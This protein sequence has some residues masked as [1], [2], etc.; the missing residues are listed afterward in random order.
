MASLNSIKSFAILKNRRWF[1]QFTYGCCVVVL[2]VCLF[3]STSYAAMPPSGAS[4][5]PSAGGS[6][7][8][9]QAVIEKV[10]QNS[11]RLKS[12]ESTVAASKGERMQSRLYT[13][14]EVSVQAENIAGSNQYKGMDSAQITYGVSQVIEI[15]GKRSSR[16]KVA[17]QGVVLSGY[18]KKAETLN[19]IRDVNIAYIAVVAAQQ[20][21]A[22]A[23]EQQAMAE[24]LYKEVKERVDAA[25][26]P[27][28]QES[29][30]QITL[31]TTQFAYERAKR[32]L[33]LAKYALS[34]LWGE[35]DNTFELAKDF[36]F[37]LVEPHEKGNIEERI[38]NTPDLKHTE[39]NYTRMQA[40]YELEKAKAIPD[41]R[42][43][44]GVRDLR[45]VKKQAFV[46]GLSMPLPVF[47]H[48]QGNIKRARH[49]AAKAK[50]DIQSTKLAMTK[51]IRNTE[52][53]QI[54]AYQNAHNIKTSIL[55]SAQKAFELSRQGYR[56]G[57][58]PYLEVLDAQRTLFDVKTQYIE[59]LKEY[60]AAKAEGERLNASYAEHK[61]LKEGK[62]EA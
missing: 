31:S 44:V 41:P 32:Q 6:T 21:L 51:G 47:N 53:A 16:M 19:V 18:E 55:P 20:L 12:I 30:A 37:N 2:S 52:N 56:A 33:D 48:N 35:Q 9:L 4:N 24:E 23:T 43:N 27:L 60:H 7:F 34:N 59:A 3:S 25:R 13:N 39:A 8:T 11:P 28:I 29:K 49:E 5:N 61:K 45:D 36:F 26:E 62:N 42:I 46:V 57:K 38:S 17:K 1:L 50:F 15:G 54:N 14:P 10:L 58:F 22:L 40:Q